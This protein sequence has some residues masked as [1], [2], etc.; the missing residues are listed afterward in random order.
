MQER[1]RNPEKL[2]PLNWLSFWLFSFPIT[3][4]V[5]NFHFKYL[6]CLAPGPLHGSAVWTELF[7]KFEI[8]LSFLFGRLS[9]T[10]AILPA[11]FALGIFEIG[12]PPF[13]SRPAWTRS[14][15]YLCFLKAGMTGMFHLTW[16]LLVEV[17]SPEFLPDPFH[18]HPHPTPPASPSLP[19]N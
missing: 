19:P 16:L 1:C 14:T 15:Y 17:G 10:W 18:P 7:T 11:H 2:S 13:M 12:S 9:T 6:A 4:P 3:H 8:W 5:G